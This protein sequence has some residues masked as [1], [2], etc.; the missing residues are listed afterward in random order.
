MEVLIM[1]NKSSFNKKAIKSGVAIMCMA[2]AITSATQFAFAESA[3]PS[4]VLNGSE[5][6]L[7]QQSVIQEGR[8][9]VPVRDI[10]VALGVDVT[11]DPTTEMFTAVKDD[12]TI[13]IQIGSNIL[14]RNGEQITLDIPTQYVNDKAMVPLRAIAEN[15]GVAVNWDANTSTASMDVNK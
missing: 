11:W 13:T 14:T 8:T 5:L 6:S 2:L 10:C 7:A 1:K 4:V 15:L 12:I 9:L 3:K